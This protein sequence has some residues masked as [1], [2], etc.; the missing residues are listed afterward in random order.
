MS[1]QM[2]CQVDGKKKSLQKNRNEFQGGSWFVNGSWIEDSNRLP[3]HYHHP[4]NYSYPFLDYLRV[5][6]LQ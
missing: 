4:L 1:L 6:M 3:E 2:S 5:Q